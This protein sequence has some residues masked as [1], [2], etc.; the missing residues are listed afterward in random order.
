M[1]S[2]CAADAVGAEG[3]ALVRAIRADPDDATAQLA[4]ADH[5]DERYGYATPQGL[6]VRCAF[7]V[8]RV[9][10]PEYA[11]AEAAVRVA[12]EAVT[13][14]F[15][16]AGWTVT[17]SGG[18]VW[19]V[20]AEFDA[21]RRFGAALLDREPVRVVELTSRPVVEFGRAVRDYRSWNRLQEHIV[22]RDYGVAHV[23]GLVRVPVGCPLVRLAGCRWRSTHGAGELKVTALLAAEWPEVV[24]WGVPD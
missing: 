3:R 9:P 7:G 23:D 14:P 15:G 10:A 2:E 18:F 22:T 1:P 12:A 24:R 8:A 5:L 16:T 19:R 21:W 11:A 6:A 13:G 4:Y 20:C 17:V